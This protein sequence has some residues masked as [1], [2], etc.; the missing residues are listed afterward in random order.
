M[1]SYN[2]GTKYNAGEKYNDP[3]DQLGRSVVDTLAFTENDSIARRWVRII[4]ETL[5]LTEILRSPMRWIKIINET[6]QFTENISL[7][8]AWIRTITE[9]LRWQD[10]IVK[11]HAKFRSVIENWHISDLTDYTRNR[12]IF[13]IEALRLT[14]VADYTRDRFYSVLE[15]LNWTE[16]ISKLRKA[17]LT[18]LATIYRRVFVPGKVMT[19]QKIYCRLGGGEVAVILDIHRGRDKTFE[20]ETR[21]ESRH[22][23][24]LTGAIVTFMVKESVK[25]ADEDAKITKSSTVQGEIVITN[26]LG[27][28]CEVH[29]VP[30]DTSSLPVRRY[31]Y[32]VKIKT[33]DGKEYTGV[34]DE[35]VIKHV[36]QRD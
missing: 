7:S 35:F 1:P 33:S 27:G 34:M 31:V 26:A 18:L 16:E 19:R 2:S 17:L 6:L 21:D 23:L 29:L 4:N 9:H 36:V 8:R 24:D 11:A 22:L 3:E 10:I 25:D 28:L 15:G 32:E 13:L 5:K 14:E 12:F 20:V 30:S